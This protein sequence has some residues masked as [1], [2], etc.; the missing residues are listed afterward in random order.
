MIRLI[1]P[2][3]II[4]LFKAFSFA[5]VAEFAPVGAEWYYSEEDFLPAPFF[6]QYPHIVEVVGKEM[7]QGKLCSKLVGV[8][9]ATVPEPLYVYAENDSVF[10]YSLVSGRFEMLYDFGAGAGDT[11]VIG[12]LDKFDSPDTLT[13]Q[14]DSVSE[15]IVDGTPLKVLHLAPT[16]LFY[17]WG[18]DIIA[19]IGNTFF[20]TPDYGLYEGGPFGLRCYTDPNNEFHFVS[21]PCD[22][23]LTTSLAENT[24]PGAGITVFPNPAGDFLQ[25]VCAQTEHDLFFRL[26]D[27]VGRLIRQLPVESETSRLETAG[28][29][30]GLYGWEVRWGNNRVAH[31]RT[32]IARN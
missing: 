8:N 24:G 26:Y 13:V 10:F 7:Y 23:T 27:P 30:A 19:G 1:I 17:D 22:T 5:Q 25:I 11:W 12:G 21:Y 6:L 32:V 2:A 3:A 29:N 4:L 9:S 16:F 28:L 15:W 18:F 14:V 31:G 20:L